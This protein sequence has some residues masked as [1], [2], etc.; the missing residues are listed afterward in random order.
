MNL[1][2][3]VCKCVNKFACVCASVWMTPS[4][5]RRT[6]IS[7]RDLREWRRIEGVE[8]YNKKRY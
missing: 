4:R 5:N 1:L 2:S 6:Q 7:E 8:Q 3:I